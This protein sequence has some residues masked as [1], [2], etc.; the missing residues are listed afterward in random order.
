MSSPF[1]FD[2]EKKSR[3]REL[4]LTYSVRRGEF[5]LASGHTSDFYVDCKQTALQAEGCLLVGELI[6]AYAQGLRAN[7]QPIEAVGGITLGADPMSA[8]AAVLGQQASAPIHAFIVRKEPKGHGTGRYVEGLGP[9]KAG[10]PVLVIEDVVTTG[11]STLKAIER[12]KEA[13]LCPVAVL[14]LV[15]REENDGAQ[16]IRDTGLPF[17]AIFRRSEL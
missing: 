10:A 15:D 16:N 17:E 9:L 5:T 7:G 2:A 11:G 4:L 13:G 12:V 1:V 6:F 3:L 8:A 14:T